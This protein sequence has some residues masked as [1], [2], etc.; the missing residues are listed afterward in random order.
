VTEIVDG[1]KK[2]RFIILTFSKLKLPP[3]PE[4]VSNPKRVCN[5]SIMENICS[6]S[7]YKI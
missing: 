7:S 4:R 1:F 5:Y 3:C 6:L 2:N